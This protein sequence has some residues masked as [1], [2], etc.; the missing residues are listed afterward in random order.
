LIGTFD[1]FNSP[2]SS[3]SLS[4]CTL[5]EIEPSKIWLG[6][7]LGDELN[8]GDDDGAVG[9]VGEALTDGDPLGLTDGKDEALGTTDGAILGETLPVGY[10]EGSGDGTALVEGG[11]VIV[12][13]G[14]LDGSLEGALLEEGNAEGPD[15]G[16]ADTLGASLG[17]ILGMTLTLGEALGEA[18]NDGD[19]DGAVGVV[20]EALTDGAVLGSS[21]T[22][23][24]S[25][26]SPVLTSTVI[27]L[28]SPPS[29]SVTS[30]KS[31]LFVSTTVYTPGGTPTKVK[32]PP[33]S[34]TVVATI[35]PLES[36]NVKVTTAIG[37]SPSPSLS[38]SSRTK[39]D[40]VL[41]SS[42]T[43]SLPVEF[44]GLPEPTITAIMLSLPPSLSETSR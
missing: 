13:L 44:K 43:K 15:E 12:A 1:K 28:G 11:G 16:S 25:G 14:E 26:L 19:D 41:P 39:P 22:K 32:A 42:S 38:T 5:P 4:S 20:G 37:A 18:L 27:T 35:A 9:V 2:T 24:R 23:M 33:E 6:A 40:T 3:L 17:R 7:P 31:G 30:T 36:T 8:D 10:E 29:L 21:S 34:V